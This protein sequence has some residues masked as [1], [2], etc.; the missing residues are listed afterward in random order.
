MDLNEIKSFLGDD[1]KKVL[2]KIDEQLGSDIEVLDST[3]RQILS[4][5]GKQ[6]RPM[7]SLL[8]ARACS[9][10]RITEASVCYAAASELLHNATLLHDDV[11]DSSD[12]R[13]GVPTIRS[14]MGASVSVLVGDYWLVKAMECILSCHTS[15]DGRVIRLFSR[16]LSDLAEGEMLQLQKAGS[17]DTTEEDYRRII[18]NKTASLFEVSAVSAAIS[19]NAPAEMEDAVR[20]YAGSLGLAFQI[21]DDIFDYAVSSA[22][23]GK[24]VG[25]D[26]MEQK[27]TLPLLGAL[28]MAGEETAA[29]IRRKVMEIHS[30]PEYREEIIGFVRD[31]GGIGYAMD[32][33]GEYLDEAVTALDVLP[34]TREKLYLIEIA[35]YVGK[36][37]S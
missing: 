32:R 29:D 14:V 20:R 24:P 31:Y 12:E 1:W 21:R 5:S 25:V 26:I 9:A 34:E 28:R 35:D 30:H 18:F 33:L 2:E 36:R 4:H 15:L 37:L 7:L 6:L 10:G 27:M 16:T 17:C 23:I 11:A 22:Q 8:V 19:V 3:N 13:R